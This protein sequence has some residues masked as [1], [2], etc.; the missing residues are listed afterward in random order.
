MYYK[1]QQCYNT[2]TKGKTMKHTIALRINEEMKKFLEKEADRL[3]S[4][5]AYVIRRII[6]KAMNND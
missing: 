6:K 3:D 1:A 5:Y 2:K 4:S